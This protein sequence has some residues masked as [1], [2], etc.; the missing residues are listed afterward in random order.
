MKKIVMGLV[1]III[2]LAACQN[3]EDIAREKAKGVTSFAE[4]VD[5]NFPV[6]ES[7]PR[8]C[9]TPDNTFIEPM[10]APVKDLPPPVPKSPDAEEDLPDTE[11]KAELI[12]TED[13]DTDSNIQNTNWPNYPDTLEDPEI[14]DESEEFEVHMFQF[15]FDPDPLVLPANSIVSVLFTSDDVDHGVSIPEFGINTGAIAP[16]A[17]ELVEFETGEP[18]EFNYG[19]NVFCG[20][21]H[22]DMEGTIIVE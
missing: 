15:G 17:S 5:A 20:S 18:G 11:Q 6:M 22:M 10:N 8:Q 19:C 9:K 21:G 2:F 7:Y 13:L 16:G 1:F 3:A 4:C 14:V 12:P